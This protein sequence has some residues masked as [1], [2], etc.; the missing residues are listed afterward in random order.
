MTS[1]AKTVEEYMNNLPEDRKKPMELLRNVLLKN[2][3]NGFEEGMNYGMIGYY[4]PHT[5]YPK[6]YHCKPTDPLPFIT[7]A[8]QKNSINFYHMGIYANKSL[9]DW[10]V[11]EY[12]KHSTRKLDMG[13][14]CIRFNKFDEI[15]FEL[16]GEL[17]TKISV[18]E[19]IET[20]EAAFVKK[21]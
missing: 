20:Y 17:V 6:G 2:I 10:F 4:V 11:A 16:L 1:A 3:P 8:S 7:F 5:I 18:S 9:Y 15:P 12:P 19:W 14:S 13:K 21:K